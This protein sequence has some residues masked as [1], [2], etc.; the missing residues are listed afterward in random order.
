MADGLSDEIGFTSEIDKNDIE[1]NECYEIQFWIEDKECVENSVTLDLYRKIT[2]NE[3][4]YNGELY[5]YNPNTFKRPDISDQEIIKVMD[6]GSLRAYD[7]ENEIWIY[8]Y[9]RK[10]YYIMNMQGISMKEADVCVPVMPSTSREEMLPEDRRQYGFDHWGTFI[11]DMKYSREGILPY[12]VVV[13]DIEASYPITYI[14]TGLYDNFLQMWK[15]SFLITLEKE[16]SGEN[17]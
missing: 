17:E 1:P 7:A 5:S 2:T 6:E 9:E 13:V 16:G 11:E 10:L 3:Y 14:T 8:Q 15:K 12:Q 4:F